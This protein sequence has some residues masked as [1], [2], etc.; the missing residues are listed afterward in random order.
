MEPNPSLKDSKAKLLALENFLWQEL[1]SERKRPTLKQV[2]QLWLSVAE[3][4][5]L[6]ANYA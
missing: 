6:L 2:R 5:H 4:R 3:I 1:M